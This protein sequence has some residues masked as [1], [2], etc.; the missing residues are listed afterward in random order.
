MDVRVGLLVLF[1]LG[2][3]WACEARKLENPFIS[4]IEINYNAQ[5]ALLSMYN[6]DNFC[7]RYFKCISLVDYYAP[8]FFSEIASI[9]P[10]AFCQKVDLCQQIAMFSAQIQEDS[11]ELCRHAVS[12]VIIKLKDPDTQLEIIEILLKACNSVETYMKKCKRVVFEYGPLIL[13]NAE[14][15]LETND[16]CTTLHACYCQM[17]VHELDIRAYIRVQYANLGKLH[18]A[19]DIENGLCL[20]L[21]FSRKLPL[22]TSSS[23]S[24]S[25]ISVSGMR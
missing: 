5:D 9:Q 7:Y 11:C 8:L 24:H 16:I 18:A 2:A 20:T 1:V 25:C 23:A 22:A 12:E 3:N 17:K 21:K 14:K 19:F 10:G 13:A 6:V 15:F 4:D